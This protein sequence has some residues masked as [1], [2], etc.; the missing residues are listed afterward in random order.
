VTAVGLCVIGAALALMEGRVAGQPPAAQLVAQATASAGMA[1][2]GAFVAMRRRESPLGW[3]M[4]AIG[5][6]TALSQVTYRYGLRYVLAPGAIAPRPEGATTTAHLEDALSP[7]LAAVLFLLFPTGRPPSARWRP[8]VVIAM[9]LGAVGVTANLLAPG[10]LADL[11]GVVNPLSIHGLAGLTGLVHRANVPLLNL[12]FLAACASLVARWRAAVGVERQQ[13][14]WLAAAGAF[15]AAL[16]VIG[17]LA[18]GGLLGHRF[19]ALAGVFFFGVLAL[20]AAVAIAVLRHRLYDIDVVISRALA[21]TVLAMFVAGSYIAIV[22]GLGAALAGGARSSPLLPIVATA[23]IAAAFHPVRVRASHFADRIVYGVRSTPYEVMSA[24]ADRLPDAVAPEEQLDLMARLLSQGTG[25]SVA[26]WLRVGETLRRVATWPQAT[27]PRPE[28]LLVDAPLGIGP[29]DRIR[30]VVHHGETLGYLTI[31]KP[32]AEP[33]SQPDERLIGGMAGQAGLLLRNTRLTVQLYERLDQLKLSRQRLVT[34]QDE[35]RRR[36]E[37][38]LH[39]G[40]QQQLV[41]L[42]MRLGMARTLAAKENAVQTADVIAQLVDDAADAVETLR[43]LAHGIYPPLLAAEGLATAL[44]SQ[45][46]KVC[47][48]VD[49]VAEQVGRYSE[50]VEA[51]VYFCCLEALQNVV[52]YAQASKASIHLGHDG[53]LLRFAVTDD[54][55]GFDSRTARRGAGLANMQDRLESVGG[56]LTLTGEVGSGTSVCGEIPMAALCR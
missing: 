39:D 44:R 3:L 4:L 17:E 2:I 29:A 42:K 46:A 56:K 20:P 27:N 33:V 47:L 11:P 38:N 10:Q 8:L 26:V 21:F 16:L 34:A 36:L 24:F 19:E 31:T 49:V 25:G 48:P 53:R 15:L 12:C 35:E 43:D 30:A 40:A 51:T 54:G 32:A 13:I 41:A 7:A 22:V 52:K 37:R 28:V 9:A 5:V 14:K 45:A 1:G 50:D 18:G 6:E 23:V 55:C